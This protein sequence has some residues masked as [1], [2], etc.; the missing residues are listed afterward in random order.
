MHIHLGF[1]SLILRKKLITGRWGKGMFNF[2]IITCA[3]GTQVIDTSLK[4]AYSA[5]TPLQMQ[6]YTEMDSQITVMDRLK[7]KARRVPRIRHKRGRSLF[8]KLASMCGL[9]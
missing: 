4:T 1:I 8:Y 3:D 6:G 2:R 9:V 7:R 5:L